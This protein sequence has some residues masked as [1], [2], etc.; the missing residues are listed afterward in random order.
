M[1]SFVLEDKRRQVGKV[2]CQKMI[3]I[4]G[5]STVTLGA[6]RDQYCIAAMLPG[7]DHKLQDVTIWQLM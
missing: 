1:A 6:T 2:I 7:C 3:I 4:F 5:C